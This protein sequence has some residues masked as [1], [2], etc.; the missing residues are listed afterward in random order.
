MRTKPTRVR[1]HEHSMS[2]FT[3]GYLHEFEFLLS[4]GHSSR[5]NLQN[6][7]VTVSD[8]SPETD[9]NETV[10]GER[11]VRHINPDPGLQS[12]DAHEN[13]REGCRTDEGV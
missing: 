7:E 11:D 1:I 10:S 9:V 3:R 4:L 12:C 8:V 5:H 2:E 13:E 6:K